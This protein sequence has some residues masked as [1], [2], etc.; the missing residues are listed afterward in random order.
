MLK[1]VNIFVYLKKDK[2]RKQSIEH[3]YRKLFNNNGR[4]KKEWERPFVKYH[5]KLR[6]VFVNF[7][8]DFYYIE[9]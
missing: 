9:V 3:V 5:N 4:I 1:K 6:Q 7:K 8:W 2:E